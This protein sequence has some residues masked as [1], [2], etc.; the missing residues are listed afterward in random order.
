MAAALILDPIKDQF[1][2]H[3]PICPTGA[4][5]KGITGDSNAPR[6][7]HKALATAGFFCWPPDRLG[8]RHRSVQRLSVALSVAQAELDGN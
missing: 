4:M 8:D 3:P 6:G 7:D 2:A 5:S 1:V